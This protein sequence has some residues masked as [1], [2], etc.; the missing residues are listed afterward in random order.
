MV[1]K[2]YYEVLGLVQG[3]QRADIDKAYRKLSLHNHPDRSRDPAAK[4]TFA[5]VA[6][7]YDTLSNPARKAIYDRFGYHGL[8]NGAPNDSNG[9][10]DPYVFHGDAQKVFQ[11][12]FGTENPFQDLFPASDEYG[13][14]NQHELEGQ[15]TRK[16][17]DAAIER[18]LLLTLEE[19]FLG[20]VKK[21]KMT[22]KVLSDDGYTTVLKD[23][24]FTIHVQP[25]WKEGTRITFAKDGDQGPN[26]V[27]ADVVFVVK[28]KPHARFVRQGN[29]LVHTCPVSLSDALTG[30]ILELMTLDGRKLSLPVNDIIMPGYQMTV[31]GEG[32]PHGK[33]GH[34]GDLVVRFNVAF[35]KSLTEDKKA[36]LRQALA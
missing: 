33:E 25:G 24:L 8:L 7:A 10:T 4:E 14:T 17:Q 36:L 1:H 35:P 9:F 30:C 2:D 19:V 12:F 6:E 29:N 26:S 22:R 15:R 31:P 3:A 13:L 16:V 28:Y 34:R 18:E 11:A 21:M 23:K 32:M 5:L 27:P 20:C